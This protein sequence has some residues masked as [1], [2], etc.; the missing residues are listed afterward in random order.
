[1]LATSCRVRENSTNIGFSVHNICYVS[2]ACVRQS[3]EVN[4]FFFMHFVRESI[5]IKWEAKKERKEQ[6]DHKH[7]T[8]RK[9]FWGLKSVKKK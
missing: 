4:F 7:K 2:V 1:M 6:K 8:Q 9:R 5:L 3:S